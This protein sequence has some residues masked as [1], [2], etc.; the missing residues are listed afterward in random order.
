VWAEEEGHVPFSP[1]SKIRRPRAPRK[2]AP[3]LPAHVDELLLGCAR[4][5]RDRLALLVL[6]DCGVRR[7]ELAGIRICDFDLAAANSPSSAR[8]RRSGSYLCAGES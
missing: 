4:T 1:A 3:L 2:T 7:A 6:L 8:A 5:S